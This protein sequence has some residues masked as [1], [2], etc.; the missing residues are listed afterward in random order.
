MLFDAEHLPQIARPIGRNFRSLVHPVWSEQKAQLIREYIR[1]FTYVTKHGVY[2][3]GFAAPQRRTLADI[4]SAKLVLEIEPKRVREFWLCD[5]D[6]N[7]AAMLEDIAVPHRSPQRRITVLPG[8]FNELVGTILDSGR[9]KAKTATFALLDQR[10]FEC[11]WQTVRTLA[12][13]KPSLDATATRIELFY[14]FA[15]GWLDRSIGSVRRPGTSARLDAWWGRP[16][17]LSLKGMQ[18]IPRARLVADR[19]RDEFGYKHV[20]AYP[21]HS[22]ARS[23][24]TMYHMIHA[25]DHDEASPLMLRAYR[26]V[27]GRV[28][29]DREFTQAEMNAIWDA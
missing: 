19:F 18:S 21:I 13:F 28:D 22:R 6:P 20:H 12:E 5:L 9:V 2:I 26:K 4:C 3:D 7:G 8:D 10:T 16:D 27:S 17:W 1:L 23:G 29:L 11:D 14:F 15:T 24:R 25:T